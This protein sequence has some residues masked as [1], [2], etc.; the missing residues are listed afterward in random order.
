[1]LGTSQRAFQQAE[2]PNAIAT[3]KYGQLLTM[4]CECRCGTHPFPLCHLL[5]Q[6]AQ[7][8]AATA[9]Y[10][11]HDLH[12]SFEFRIARP[13]LDTI[14]GTSDDQRVTLL[15]PKVAKNLLWDHDAG[16]IADRDE[17]QGL[18]HTNVIT[19]RATGLN[20]LLSLQLPRDFPQM[21]CL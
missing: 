1:M 7:C 8:T 4:G 21:G 15:G 6:F 17:F 12:I 16:R 18:V 10:V 19:E 5:R 13:E 9:H 20:L 14:W 11:A 2:V 3:T